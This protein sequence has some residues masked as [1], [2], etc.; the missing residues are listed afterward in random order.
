MVKL[1]TSRD[2]LYK[3]INNREDNN[4]DMTLL[5]QISNSSSD[6]DG[7]LARRILSAINGVKNNTL[8]IPE[9]KFQV[10]KLI[11]TFVKEDF[12][13]KDYIIDAVRHIL[14]RQTNISSL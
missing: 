1:F 7:H 5:T 14:D 6:I 8:T 4:M 13:N 10:R 11:F 3:I 9:A 2:S 12:D